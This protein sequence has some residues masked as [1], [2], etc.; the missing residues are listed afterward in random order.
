MGKTLPNIVTDGPT[1]NG[2]HPSGDDWTIGALLRGNVG[3]AS[4]TTT[5]QKPPRTLPR[6]E[7][8]MLL[9]HVLSCRRESLIAH[10]E[11][12]LSRVE[13]AAF[14]DLVRQRLDG[15]PIA[16]LTRSRE[17]Y[18][19][20]LEI[21]PSVLIPRPETELLVDAA[22]QRLSRRSKVTILDLGTGSGAIAIALA[23][24]LPDALIEAVDRSDAALDVARR[25]VARHRLT[26]VDVHAA[27]WYSGVRSA[28]FDVIVSNPPYVRE[29]DPHLDEGDVR[30]E[31][32]QALTAG[33]DG[34]AAIRTIAAG[35]LSRLKD[36]GTLLVEHGH[37]QGDACRE[38]FIVAGLTDVET[39]RDLAG[40]DRVCV[41]SL[42]KIGQAE[43]SIR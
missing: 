11:R 15:T 19:I 9:A 26:S 8:S 7:V 29:E 24:N 39:L 14:V 40:H 37:D 41:G 5:V 13:S 6:L 35:A 32:R 38:I 22:L 3:W 18:G 16:Y 23:T 1:V 2:N 31:P 43:H 28:A 4:G 12:V 10:P 33:R 25:N 36:G 34:L 42:S 20:L 27:D 17:F 21:D 30:F